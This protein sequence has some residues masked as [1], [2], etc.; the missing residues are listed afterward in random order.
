MYSGD[1]IELDALMSDSYD[2]DHII[3]RS[4]SKDDS[5]DNKVLVSAVLNR[6]KKKNTYPVPDPCRPP[7]AV[8]FGTCLKPKIL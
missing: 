1:K 3:P 8:S 2:V 4:V 6:Y 7:K 5:L